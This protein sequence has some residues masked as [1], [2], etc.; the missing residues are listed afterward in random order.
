MAGP[1]DPGVT[2]AGMVTA[3]STVPA[4]IGIVPVYPQVTVWPV[5]VQDQLVPLAVPGTTPVGRVA[6]ND[7]A[8]LRDP[9]AEVKP[10]VAV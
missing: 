7:V 4:G 2:F 8:W 6:T 1:D 5:V 9:P 3:G 10:P